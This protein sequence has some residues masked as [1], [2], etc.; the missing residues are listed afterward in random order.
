MIGKSCYIDTGAVIGDD[1][2]IQNFVSVYSGVTVEDGVFVGP[3]VVFTNDPYPKVT[4]EWEMQPT[5]VRSGAAI[6][7]N[8]T[9]LCG[10]TIGKGAMVGAGAVVTK[11][12]EDGQMVLGNPAR[13][14]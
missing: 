13:P 3:S 1:C 11:D 10:L 4:G 14:I 7:A 6:G 8:A 12:V 2:K 9:I 5:L